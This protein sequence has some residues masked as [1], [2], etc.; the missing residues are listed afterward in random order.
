[1]STEY[2]YYH[3][4]AKAVS[5]CERCNRLLCSDC[6]YTFKNRSLRTFNNKID[7]LYDEEE[8]IEEKSYMEKVHWCY[9]CYYDYFNPRIVKSTQLIHQLWVS[10]VYNLAISPIIILLL[11]GLSLEPQSGTKIPTE[12]YLFLFLFSFFALFIA[13]L[14][15][16]RRRVNKKVADFNR[17]V[18]NFNR[19]NIQNVAFPIECFFC[20]EK[21]ESHSS[22]CLNINCTLGEQLDKNAQIIKIEPI[23]YNLGLLETLNE[24]PKDPTSTTSHQ[25]EKNPDKK[26]F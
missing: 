7:E 14:I 24:L 4:Y 2:C 17:F 26:G 9:P 3:S 10:F 13:F 20:K 25:S 19:L 22:I 23:K 1:M 11:I 12:I 8:Y 15:S 5:S 16:E 21:I 6:I 18:E